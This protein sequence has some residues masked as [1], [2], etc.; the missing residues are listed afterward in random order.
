M[1]LAAFLVSCAVL[2]IRLGE[3]EEGD[4]F[5]KK[6]GEANGCLPIVS[7]RTAPP[8]TDASRPMISGNIGQDRTA[9]EWEGLSFHVSQLS[10]EYPDIAAW[11]WIPGTSV[12]YPVMLGRDNEF[13]LD[14]LPNGQE[15]V[16]GSLF[17]DYRSYWDC[18]RGHSPHLIIYGHSGSGGRMFGALKKYESQDFF[19]EHTV[20]IAATPEAAYI[21]PIFS[22]RRVEA[23]GDAYLMEFED[24]DAL[25]SY[26]CQAAEESIYPTD[27][28]L[29]YMAGILTLSTCTGYSGQRLVVQAILPQL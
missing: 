28:C 5:Y 20:L 6:M 7:S 26:A 14:H 27:A 22:V 23:G 17:L 8:I 15:H 9:E 29:D 10:Q 3:L 16:L 21:C 1:V 2:G 13:Y 24:K 11:L 19:Q 4:S 25:M 18:F 12:N